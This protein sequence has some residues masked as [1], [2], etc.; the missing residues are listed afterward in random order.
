[1]AK[2]ICF[3]G[4]HSAGK[5]KS[6]HP[7]YGIRRLIASSDPAWE[8]LD[9]SVGMTATASV[10]STAGY[11]DFDGADIYKDMQRVTI[12]NQVFVQ[13]PKFYYQRFVMGGYDYIRISQ[14][15]HDGFLLHPAFQYD[16]NGYE[17]EWVYVGAYL[18]G[19]NG[20]S[21]TGL[22]I[23]NAAA[24][25][26]YRSNANSIVTGGQCIDITILSMIRF[27]YLV[28]FATYAS[29]KVLGTGT[30]VR[31]AYF[32]GACDNV[33]NL[34]GNDGG[35]DGT[36]RV[37][38][39]GIEDIYGEYWQWIDSVYKTTANTVGISIKPNAASLVTLS[40]IIIPQ[41][42]GFITHHGC[43]TN[44]PW[45]LVPVANTGGS[46][47]TYIGD[48]SYWS[49][50]Q[51]WLIS[52]GGGNL[53]T[54]DALNQVGMFADG[55]NCPAATITNNTSISSRLCMKA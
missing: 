39:R 51:N 15:Q 33:P 2:G 23:M 25:A 30:G 24:P 17:A 47:D 21:Q 32:T 4:G 11:S 22:R 40:S 43:D 27:L 36:C 42:Q 20:V 8:R 3:L 19:D 38:Y 53:T 29:Q 37:I 5:T 7:I 13:V 26:T 12:H 9:D 1:M 6:E 54:T 34:T 45:F 18:M 16:H 31:S 46:A 50:T 28:E 44:Y 52:N 55:Y 49:S 35:G 10:G 48:Y 14:Y 41:A